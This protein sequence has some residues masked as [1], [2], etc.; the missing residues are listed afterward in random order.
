[1]SSLDIDVSFVFLARTSWLIVMA[2]RLH[3]V[4]LW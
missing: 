2:Q 3:T 1:M 4:L